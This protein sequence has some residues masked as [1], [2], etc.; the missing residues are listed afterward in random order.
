MYGEPIKLN[1][2]GQARFYT[3]TGA[4]TS[5]LV[6]LAILTFLVSRLLSVVSYDAETIYST[7]STLPYNETVRFDEMSGG[8]SFMFGFKTDVIGK[9]N[10]EESHGHI[11][12]YLQKYRKGALVE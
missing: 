5:G 1:F 7:Q 4:V 6:R 2:R 10:F 12:F 3:Y 8:K 11:E 9:N